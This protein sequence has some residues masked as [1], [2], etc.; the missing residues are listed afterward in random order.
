MGPC[1][2]IV[3]T[4]CW[5]AARKASGLC[6]AAW[7]LCSSRGIKAESALVRLILTTQSCVALHAVWAA[8]WALFR[9]CCGYVFYCIFLK[10][11]P[12][13]RNLFPAKAHEHKKGQRE[14]SLALVNKQI[15]SLGLGCCIN[16]SR[17][18]FTLWSSSCFIAIE[19]KRTQNVLSPS[20]WENKP[21]G[22]DYYI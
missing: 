10:E 14:A 8:A 9:G 6:R 3:T 12:V 17:F 18:G 1:M 11:R 15:S 5:V 21:T 7:S 2:V 20:L 22:R 4:W 13:L 16:S 19:D